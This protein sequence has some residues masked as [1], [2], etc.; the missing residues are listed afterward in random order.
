MAL[1]NI[2][3]SPQIGLGRLPF[4]THATVTLNNAT[5]SNNVFAAIVILQPNQTIAGVKIVGGGAPAGTPTYNVSVEGVTNSGAGYGGRPNGTP[6]TSTGGGSV[7]MLIEDNSG[8]AVTNG[9]IVVHEFVDTYT[10]PGPGPQMIALTIRTGTTGSG[11]NATNNITIRAGY[12]TW[13]TNFT[14]PHYSTL[15]SGSWAHTGN[16]PTMWAVDATGK[17]TTNSSNSPTY[18]NETNWNSAS[19]PNRRGL[20]WDAQFGCRVSAFQVAWRPAANSNPE[21]VINV[22]E[23]DGVTL[24]STA[25][26]TYNF[27]SAISSNPG[28]IFTQIP[29]PPTEVS[30]GNVVRIFLKPDATANAILQFANLEW[31]TSLERN[32]F[33]GTSSSV[34]QY[35]SSADGTTWTDVDTKFPLLIPVIDQIDVGSA[36]TTTRVRRT[37]MMTPDGRIASFR[38]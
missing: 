37:Q 7:P 28:M 8:A 23:N 35:T 26:A 2:N 38:G 31:A 6:L 22:Y 15:T 11:L 25:T 10:N 9:A 14:L 12:Q 5:A 16:C 32:A 33:F 13:L 30:A 1:T 24:K 3:P 18:T 21:F 17:V 34:F 29:I 4:S 19:S 27:Y 20:R 36:T